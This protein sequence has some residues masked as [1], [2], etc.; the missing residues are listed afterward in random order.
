[1][2]L[3]VSWIEF[4][5]DTEEYLLHEVFSGPVAVQLID[6]ANTVEVEREPGQVP[7]MIAREID[8]RGDT[9]FAGRAIGQ[10]CESVVEGLVDLRA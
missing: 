2:G 6:A 1:M 9:G 3:G 5:R 7:L 10:A 8:G 4:V